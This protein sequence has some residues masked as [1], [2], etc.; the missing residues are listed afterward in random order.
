M[1]IQVLPVYTH[2]LRGASYNYYPVIRD[3]RFPFSSHNL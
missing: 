3:D 1:R 2:S